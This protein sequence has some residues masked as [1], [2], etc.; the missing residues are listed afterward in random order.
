MISWTEPKAFTEAPF[1]IRDLSFIYV[2]HN[3]NFEIQKRWF[4]SEGSYWAGMLQAD[5]NLIP[6]MADED[7]TF[8]GPLLLDLRMM[9]L[10]AHTLYT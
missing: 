3:H 10:R 1:L 6:F 4:P 7:K 8:S 9:K 5:I 2:T